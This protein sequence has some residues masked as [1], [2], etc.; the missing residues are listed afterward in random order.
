M[1]V[2]TGS[3]DGTQ[4]LIRSYCA[5]YSWQAVRAALGRLLRINRNEALKLAHGKGDYLFFID[6]DDVIEIAPDFVMPQLDKDYYF[7]EAIRD[8]IRMFTILMVNNH[9]DW[10]WEGVLHEAL[11]APPER[12]FD[13]LA[14]PLSAMSQKMAPVQKIQRLL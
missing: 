10:C 1:I 4:E 7:L 5:R 13:F 9:L 2:D 14:L 6:A 11:Q 12:S 3:T 8:R